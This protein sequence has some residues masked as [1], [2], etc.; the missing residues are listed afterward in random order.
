MNT[1]GHIGNFFKTLFGGNEAHI[2]TEMTNA[3]R[4]KTIKDADDIPKEARRWLLESLHQLEFPNKSRKAQ[5]NRSNLAFQSYRMNNNNGSGGA[6]VGKRTG[7]EGAR[8]Q[9]TERQIG[10]K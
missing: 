10:E 1:I 6:S 5:P 9:G 8:V 2:T 4:I 7:P 3:Q